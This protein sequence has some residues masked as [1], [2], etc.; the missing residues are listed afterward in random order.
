MMTKV[1][2]SNPIEDE[3]DAIRD[4]IC[5]EGMTPAEEIE[6]FRRET[7]VVIKQYDFR[8]IKSAGE[9]PESPHA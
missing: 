7:E 2:M 1:K 3:I 6:Y 4:K 5:E 9:T 8:V